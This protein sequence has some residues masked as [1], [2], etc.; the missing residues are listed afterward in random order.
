MRQ[1]P[2]THWPMPTHAAQHPVLP[3][4]LS[5]ARSPPGS[6]LPH[7]LSLSLYPFSF[8][9]R[10]S[11][12]LSVLSFLL[13][14]SLARFLRYSPPVCCS[15]PRPVSSAVRRQ[16]SLSIPLAGVSLSFSG[17]RASGVFC[18][19]LAPARRCFYPPTNS[20]VHG[21]RAR[22]R[23]SA[24]AADPERAREWRRQS[25]IPTFAGIGRGMRG[26]FLRFR[27]LDLL[28]FPTLNI[29]TRSRIW[30][31]EFDYPFLNKEMSGFS[32]FKWSE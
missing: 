23:S 32:F 10:L 11:L 12:S 1:Q 6:A 2:L 5:P 25:S 17:V 14:R 28:E 31:N 19:S 27:I 29:D 16:L 3:P 13:S 18:L 22:V 24:T 20:A 26:V 30:V 9:P 8:S 15:F 21:A 4:A 7:S